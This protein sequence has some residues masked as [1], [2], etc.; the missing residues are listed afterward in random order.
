MIHSFDMEATPTSVVQEQKKNSCSMMTTPGSGDERC[1]TMIMYNEQCFDSPQDI[2]ELAGK[3][4]SI[5][6]LYHVGI[7]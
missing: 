4:Y 1:S 7:I 3:N 6:R 5:Y 2:R